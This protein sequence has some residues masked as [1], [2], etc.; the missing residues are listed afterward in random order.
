MAAPEQSL[1]IRANACN[2][3]PAAATFPSK[4]PSQHKLQTG[5]ALKG[6][7]AVLTTSFM[8]TQQEHLSE[9]L[10]AASHMQWPQLVLLPLHFVN[11][12]P[13][14][15]PC[16]VAGVRKLH[17]PTLPMM[18]RKIAGQQ[19]SR[20]DGPSLHSPSR[21]AVSCE[22]P[23]NTPHEYEKLAGHFSNLGTTPDQTFAFAI[24]SM[25]SL[26]G[27]SSLSSCCQSSLRKCT[28]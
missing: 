12:R 23:H 17:M 18:P 6:A 25:R 4:K 9:P 22:L 27:R 11:Q 2:D 5:F 7:V 1:R 15:P 10:E 19:R 16:E 8:S 26:L 3:S 24:L 28:K 14:P 20:S 21:N 13:R